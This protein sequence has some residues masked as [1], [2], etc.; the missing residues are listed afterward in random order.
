M[1]MYEDYVA[2]HLMLIRSPKVIGSAVDKKDLKKLKSFAGM[3]D[4]SGHLAGGVSIFP[5]LPFAGMGD[6]SGT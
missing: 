6:P 5:H 4:P 3:S 1:A 2:T